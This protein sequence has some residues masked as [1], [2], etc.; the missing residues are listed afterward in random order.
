M[1]LYEMHLDARVGSES[2]KLIKVR[3]LAK[4]TRNTETRKTIDGQRTGPWKGKDGGA[5]LRFGTVDHSGQHSLH[6]V[7]VAAANST[8]IGQ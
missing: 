3:M 8:T 6:A 7:Y 4:C 1:C 2:G 5:P